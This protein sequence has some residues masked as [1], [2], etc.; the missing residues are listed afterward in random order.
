MS[1][2]KIEKAV[3]VAE[4]DYLDEDKPIRNQ[5]YVCLSF[6]SPEDVIL[7][8]EVVFFNKYIA[9]F[10]TEMTALFNGLKE[11]YPNDE[12]SINS[13][14][15]NYSYIFSAGELQD[16]FKFFKGI[17]SQQLESDYHSENEFKTTV[18]GIKVRGTYDTL[19]EAQVRAE[20]LKKMGDKFDIFVAQVGCWCPW[21][22]RPEDMED[23]Q[24]SETQ[25]NTIMGKYKENQI[26][27]D[28]FYNERKEE[29]ILSAKKEAERI[30]ANNLVSSPDDLPDPGKTVVELLDDASADVSREKEKSV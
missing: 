7:D 17:N 27:R 11:K 28:A 25:L 14:R 6:I 21:S 4:T 16:Q 9:S 24:Y 18:R 10:A 1:Y 26:N 12:S 8:K 5:N 20:V 3:P 2:S 22:P 19:K 13:L 30:S 23:Q 29:K 15:E